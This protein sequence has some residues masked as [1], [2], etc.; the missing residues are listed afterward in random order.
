MT[1]GVYTIQDIA[2]IVGGKVI[3]TPSDQHIHYL[4]TDSRKIIFP[5]SSVFFALKGPQ[6]NG[7]SFIS[8]AIDAGVKSMI[9]S[10]EGSTQHPSACFVLVNDTTEAL[11]KLAAHHRQQFT[12][13]VVGVTGSNGKTIV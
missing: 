3:G 2:T 6:H 1:K 12:I 13:P 9:V 10:E 4:I 7:H 5:E 8:K 11:Q